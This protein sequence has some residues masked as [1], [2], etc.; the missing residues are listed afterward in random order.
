LA[1][2]QRFAKVLDRKNPA[3]VGIGIWS[4]ELLWSLVLGSWSFTRRA[5]TSARN[6][7]Y[8][9]PVATCHHP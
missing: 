5:Q 4:L 8:F 2:P 3:G 9:V 6:D 7:L 1:I